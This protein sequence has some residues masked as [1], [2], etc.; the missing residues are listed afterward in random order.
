MF[1]LL[2]RLM[3]LSALLELGLTASEFRNCRSRQCLQNGSVGLEG[4]HFR[5]DAGR[6]GTV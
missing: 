4:Y 6:M 3:L 1:S 5:Q 2:I